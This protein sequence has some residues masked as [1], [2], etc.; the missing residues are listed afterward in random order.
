MPLLSLNSQANELINWFYNSQFMRVP[1]VK[2]CFYVSL[3][4]QQ[5][6]NFSKKWIF[7]ETVTMPS[8]QAGTFALRNK[9]EVMLGYQMVFRGLGVGV[10][11]ASQEGR[12]RF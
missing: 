6:M 7:Q 9:L 11:R 8:V 10:M 1:K 2:P 5:D 4:N 12:R 3:F